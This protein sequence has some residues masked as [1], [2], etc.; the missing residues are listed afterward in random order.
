MS[1]AVRDTRTKTTNENTLSPPEDGGG[2]EQGG[3]TDWRGCGGLG[4][5]THSVLLGMEDGTQSAA[6][7]KAKHSYR[8]NQQFHS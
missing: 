4:T 3:L 8:V 1:L 5:L 2:P 7:R 6:P